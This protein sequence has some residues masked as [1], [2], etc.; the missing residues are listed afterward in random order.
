MRTLSSKRVPSSTDHDHPEMD[1]LPLLSDDGMRNCQM[2]VGMA[3][4]LVIVGRLDTTHAVSSLSQF[5][6]APREGHVMAM[7]QVW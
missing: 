4:L 5:S 7:L 2:S 6:C 1:E 3:Q